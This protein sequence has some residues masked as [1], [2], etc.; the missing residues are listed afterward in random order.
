MDPRFKEIFDNTIPHS[1]FLDERSIL[2]C[3]YQ[4]YQ[5]GYEDV[6]E[7]LSKS[8]FLTDDVKIIKREWYIQN[9]NK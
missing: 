8:D 9:R 7:W 6:F 2:G 3:M 1:S 5:L 4:S